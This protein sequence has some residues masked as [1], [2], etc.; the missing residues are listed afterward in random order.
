MINQAA[1]NLTN[2]RC[3]QYNN[4]KIAIYYKVGSTAQ[5]YDN[6]EK[7]KGLIE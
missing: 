1:N 4:Q 2:L 6:A 3:Q 7:F 5:D